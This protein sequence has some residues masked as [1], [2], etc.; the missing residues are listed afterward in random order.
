MT[1]R[2]FVLLGAVAATL[3]GCDGNDT[4]EASK[5][6]DCSTFRFSP[7]AWKQTTKISPTK[8]ELSE[9]RR[10]ASGVVDCGLLNDRSKR[11]VRRALGPPDGG[12]RQLDTWEFYVGPERG[13]FVLDDEL[14]T[15]EF[16]KGRVVRVSL[17]AS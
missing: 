16:A 3:A 6:T 4:P 8:R 13:P 10:L 14:I 12:D 2:R 11:Q 9:R 1:V 7:A 5:K 17:G 15:I